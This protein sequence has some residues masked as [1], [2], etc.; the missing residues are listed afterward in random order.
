L[1]AS[2][3]VNHSAKYFGTIQINDSLNRLLAEQPTEMKE[4]VYGI[5]QSNFFT[6]TTGEEERAALLELGLS[7]AKYIA[8][9]PGLKAHFRA[10]LCSSFASKVA[11][12][13]AFL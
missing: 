3:I 12:V 7:Q 10:S 6:D 13:S 9:P 4:A 5:I 11:S 2:D 8:E 1:A